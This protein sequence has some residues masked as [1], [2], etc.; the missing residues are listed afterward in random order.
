MGDF[1]L[2]RRT[3]VHVEGLIGSGKSTLLRRLETDALGFSSAVVFPCFYEPVQRW[4]GEKGDGLNFL[5]AVYR[6]PKD[7]GFTFQQYVGLTLAE[8]ELEMA[9]FP[10]A[11]AE[12]SISGS[13][14]VFAKNLNSAGF[15]DPLEFKVLSAYHDYFER[16]LLTGVRRVYVLVDVSPVTALSRI[17][18]R[19]RP[20]ESS[21]DLSFLT[22]LSVL[23]EEFLLALVARDPSSLVVRISGEGDGDLVFQRF[24]DVLATLTV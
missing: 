14:H 23:H 10:F 8:R 1:N 16:T 22:S 15:L 21:I 6:D 4:L 3:V 12:R 2:S 19:D 11:V 18:L 24:Q 9:R 13:Y 5:D 17:Q 20:E 7:H